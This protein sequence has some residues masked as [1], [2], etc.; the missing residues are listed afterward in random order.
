MTE[1]TFRGS[2]SPINQ[3]IQ[4]LVHVRI[5]RRHCFVALKKSMFFSIVYWFVG[6]FVCLLLELP[7]FDNHINPKHLECYTYRRSFDH[8]ILPTI[9]LVKLVLR[10]RP[11]I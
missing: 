7:V 3:H 11:A 8:W 6:L 5:C 4:W 2:T 9:C 10:S 1:E